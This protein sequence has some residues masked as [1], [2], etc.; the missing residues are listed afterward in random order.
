MSEWWY[1]NTLFE[2]NSDVHLMTN[3]RNEKSIM[4]YYTNFGRVGELQEEIDMMRYIHKIELTDGEEKDRVKDRIVK[5]FSIHIPSKMIHME[6]ADGTDLE[7][8]FREYQSDPSFF[9]MSELETVMKQ[10]Y[11]TLAFLHRIGVAHRDIKDSNVVWDR[12]NIKLIDFGLSCFI[13]KDLA[14]ENSIRCT[15]R[16]VGTPLF[17]APEVK[18]VLKKVDEWY[19][20]DV[21]SAS[22]IAL[23]FLTRFDNWTDDD[24]ALKEWIDTVPPNI[25]NSKLV[26][27]TILGTSRQ[28]IRPSA[29][30]LRSQL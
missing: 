29:S 27:V 17:M 19:L 18:N 11:S 13:P 7:L 4:K 23:I 30:F 26:N 24:I 12:Q 5:Y 22:M 14:P 6:Y 20:A 2:G 8:I 1:V 9:Q 10:L 15:T 16:T 3:S 21:Y 25:F 28:K